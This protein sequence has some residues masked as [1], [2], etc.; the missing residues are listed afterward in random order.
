MLIA[1][2]IYCYFDVT[3]EPQD[4]H[5]HESICVHKEVCMCVYVIFCMCMCESIIAFQCLSFTY[6]CVCSCKHVHA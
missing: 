3:C 6:V 5:V 2:D 1:F 4:R